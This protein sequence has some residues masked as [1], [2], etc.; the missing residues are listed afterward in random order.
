MK[1]QIINALI[2]FSIVFMITGC[3]SSPE[4]RLKSIDFQKVQQ[5]VDEEDPQKSKE[6]LD[7][8]IEKVGKLCD[9]LKAA[10]IENRH[11]DAVDQYR[12]YDFMTSLGGI[13]IVQENLKNGTIVEISGK[14]REE[15]KFICDKL[16]F[17]ANQILN[18][19]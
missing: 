13:A 15:I 19:K 2:F 6:L 5:A 10:R 11:F 1:H 17:D 4:G 3:F 18:L 12:R 16:V 9:S 8:Q 14:D 7:P